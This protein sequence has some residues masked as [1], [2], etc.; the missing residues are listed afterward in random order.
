MTEPKRDHWLDVRLREAYATAMA[1]QH[2]RL[3]GRIQLYM[4]SDVI[5]YLK[6]LCAVPNETLSRTTCWGF[7]TFP[8]DGPP[9]H[10]S[11]HTVQTIP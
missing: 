4:G 1:Q 3:P 10:I 11:V 2:Q 8:V 9:D 7:D 6:S 5:A